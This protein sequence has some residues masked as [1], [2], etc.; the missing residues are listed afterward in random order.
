MYK[1]YTTESSSLETTED[2]QRMDATITAF[3][4]IYAFKI[5]DIL[6]KQSQLSSKT[7][8][9]GNV[10]VLAIQQMNKVLSVVRIF[11]NDPSNANQGLKGDPQ[12]VKKIQ[13]LIEITRN[14]QSLWKHQLSK[15]YLKSI[16][17]WIL[18][19]SIEFYWVDDRAKNFICSQKP[20]NQLMAVLEEKKLHVYYYSSK[21]M[22]FKLHFGTTI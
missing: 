17:P 22:A 3:N 19:S 6:L 12:K 4:L 15:I 5:Y 13:R 16:N 9:T 14:I 10:G 11:M 2:S 18:F 1:G 20:Q 7:V 21:Q 8:N